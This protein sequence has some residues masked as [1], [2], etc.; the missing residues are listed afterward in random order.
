MITTQD[1]YNERTVVTIPIV[2]LPLASGAGWYEL[3]PWSERWLAISTDKRVVEVPEK[4]VAERDVRFVR[5]RL[6]LARER[7][8]ATASGVPLE[9]RWYDVHKRLPAPETQI[10]LSTT[11]EPDEAPEV[12]IGYYK[13]LPSGGP[14]WELDVVH[15]GREDVERDYDGGPKV[16]RVT[17]WRPLVRPDGSIVE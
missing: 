1:E 8:E 10:L 15:N 3:T 6:A 2:S 17:H 4:D 5:A 16:R 12:L 7:M 11:T 14:A 13:P 9:D